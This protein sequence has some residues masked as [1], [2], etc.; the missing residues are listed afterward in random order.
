MKSI[1]GTNIIKFYRATGE[2]GFFSNLYKK[3]LIF[4]DREF[5]CGESAYQYGKF[6]DEDTRKW[7]MES[8]KPHLLSILAH[9]LFVWDI[10]SNWSKIKVN[11]MYNVLKVK[12]SDPELKEKLLNTGNSVLIE[13][14][15]TDAFWGIGKLGKG[16][17]TLGKLL[18][19]LREEIK[20]E[21]YS[22]QNESSKQ[23]FLN[24]DTI[25]PGRIP[26]PNP[27]RDEGSFSQLSEIKDI[28]E[29]LRIWCTKCDVNL[30]KKGIALDCPRDGVFYIC[31]SCNY[32]IVVFE[33]E[34][35]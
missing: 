12:F 22:C 1:E 25:S 8:P 17:N 10:V 5:S 13:N 14:S 11:R 9:G 4:E 19:R 27:I 2:Y 7:A 16:K 30:I 23:I 31:P 35:D 34:G 32:R 18:M 3:P 26:I 15:K 6:R 21:N 28:E 24:C 33:N 20:K 29:K